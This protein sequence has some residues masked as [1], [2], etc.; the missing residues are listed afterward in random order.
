MRALCSRPTGRLHWYDW[1]MSG[2]RTAHLLH[3]LLFACIVTITAPLTAAAMGEAANLM[4]S[5]YFEECPCGQ[6]PNP[7]KGNGQPKCVQGVNRHDCQVGVCYDVTSGITT[8]GVCV[9]ENKCEGRLCDGKPCEGKPEDVKVKEDGKPADTKTTPGAAQGGAGG[10]QPLKDQVALQPTTKT[11]PITGEPIKADGTSPESSS[12]EPGA[13]P[14]DLPSVDRSVMDQYMKYPVSGLDAPDADPWSKPA[15]ADS[16]QEFLKDTQQS[17][18]AS[19]G[20]LS[21]MGTDIGSALERWGI[22]TPGDGVSLQPV[23]AEGNAVGEPIKGDFI[24]GSSE[25]TG[26]DGSD[27]S[28]K[29]LQPITTPC[30]SWWSCMAER[31]GVLDEAKYRM[32]GKT[33]TFY[34]PVQGGDSMQGGLTTSRPGLD[35]LSRV[36]TL[37]DVRRWV[38]SGGA[39][40]KPYV[41][42]ATAPENNGKFYSLGEVTYKSNIDGKE[43]TLKDVVGY[44]HDTGGAF[45]AGGCADYGT[46]SVRL[47]KIDVAEGVYSS[48]KLAISEITNNMPEISSMQQITKSAAYDIMASAANPAP[49]AVPMPTPRPWGLGA[50]EVPYLSYS[51]N[52]GGSQAALQGGLPMSQSFTADGIPTWAS[53]GGQSGIPTTPIAPI[54]SSAFASVRSDGFSSGLYSSPPSATYDSQYWSGPTP[55]APG[56]EPGQTGAIVQADV[57]PG[58]TA[59]SYDIP[60]PESAAVS[61]EQLTAEVRAA[62]DRVLTDASARVPTPEMFAVDAEAV[63]REIR[64]GNAA[65]SASVPMPESYLLSG[66]QLTSDVKAAWGESLTRSLGGAQTGDYARIYD[67]FGDRFATEMTP[68]QVRAAEA[69]QLQDRLAQADVETAAYERQL[70]AAADSVPKPEPYVQ[71]GEQITADIQRQNARD[72]AIAISNAVPTPE[73]YQVSG[74]DLTKQVLDASQPK[75]WWQSTYDRVASWLGSSEVPAAPDPS[76]YAYT[77]NPFGDEKPL[78]AAEETASPETRAIEAKLLQDRL[79]QAD[80]ETTA[81]EQRLKN[82]QDLIPKPEPVKLTADEIMQDIRNNTKFEDIPV[83]KPEYVEE[84]MK[85]Y[86]VTASALD[87]SVQKLTTGAAGETPEQAALKEQ[88]AGFEAKK[89]E[90]EAKLAE[91]KASKNIE[92]EKKLYKDIVTLNTLI[93]RARAGLT[94]VAGLTWYPNAA[95]EA[96]IKDGLSAAGQ[97]PAALQ[98]IESNP[99]AADMDASSKGLA[100]QTAAIAEQLKG[101]N[102]TNRSSLVSSANSILGQVNS[103]STKAGLEV[104][105]VINAYN[106]E[107]A[108]YNYDIK[109]AQR[110]ITDLNKQY[111]ALGSTFTYSV[112]PM[113]AADPI[114]FTSITGTP[115]TT[116]LD[117]AAHYAAPDVET[118]AQSGGVPIPES[119]YVSG[120][121]LTADVL[122]ASQSKSWWQSAYEGVTSWWNAPDVAAAPDPSAYAYTQNPFG[123]QAPLDPSPSG[124][125]VDGVPVPEAYQVSGEDLTKEIAASAQQ[126]SWLS[127]AYDTVRSTWNDYFGTTPTAPNPSDYAYTQNPF[128]DDPP[129]AAQVPDEATAEVKAI[130]ARLLQDRLAQADAEYKAYMERYDNADR[131]VPKPV[132]FE[133]TAEQ[134]TQQIREASVKMVTET[135]P[136]DPGMTPTER[137]AAG[138]RSLLGGGAV[139]TKTTDWNAFYTAVSPALKA[140]EPVAPA[141]GDTAAVKPGSTRSIGGDVVTAAPDATIPAESVPMPRPRPAAAGTPAA[142]TPDA[143]APEAAPA[144]VPLPKPRPAAA[145]EPA[146]PAPA[147]A[148]KSFAER[149]G[150]GVRSAASRIASFF[151]GGTPSTASGSAAGGSNAGGGIG[152][153]LGSL[154][155]SMFGGSKS[156]TASASFQGTSQPY[157]QPPTTPATTTPTVPAVTLVAN[158]SAVDRGNPSTISWTAAG[159]AQC[160]LFSPD[161]TAVATGTPSGSYRVENIT[162]SVTY[163]VTCSGGTG[164]TNG[165]VTILMR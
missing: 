113:P 29:S 3:V 81:Y 121:Q 144:A 151:S 159:S 48:G 140:D 163:K 24:T 89:A 157:V 66:E 22:I 156:G 61:G 59:G 42:L 27:A 101:M 130:E 110:S 28:S 146:S 71:T 36:S 14:A 107:L 65:I 82:A 10:D 104:G 52:M 141:G 94:T 11:D 70:K 111:T 87:P 133:Q 164:S 64:S 84:T 8:Q 145:D 142:A 148:P 76:T 33:V 160:N 32:D 75:S 99:A 88:I 115:Y 127:S 79:S 136:T 123:D 45:T 100:S 17:A 124:R 96:T 165:Q 58:S 31:F 109:A 5:P 129:L 68:E 116:G 51:M 122:A 60:V 119:Y 106:G 73:P 97:I 134:I 57:Q 139:D 126:K 9:T 23:D 93:N 125:V 38:E 143:T 83:K 15:S 98:R 158:P 77:Q 132:A 112:P 1:R 80:A 34:G 128:G 138:V 162:A 39:N 16:I 91:F 25:S 56:F 49:E 6:V 26:F 105:K 47:S 69:Q 90:A 44:S 154:F 161:G 43:Y 46:C 12:P 108:G 102:A 67:A 37:D 118:P 41:T 2:S 103:F 85:L 120:E 21:K 137:L 114:P 35:G 74:E 62:W 54:D 63:M 150:D 147:A 20:F 149:V 95:Q 72:A 18:E 50:S 153:M 131:F 78:V 92:G 40:G 13:K 135:A 19:G 55:G 117:Y 155:S 86:P 30:D 53:S 7:K 152:S 4:C